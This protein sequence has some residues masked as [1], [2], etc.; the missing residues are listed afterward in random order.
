MTRTRRIEI[1]IWWCGSLTWW[2]GQ[3]P[4]RCTV[5]LALD[6]PSSDL[7]FVDLTRAKATS[8]SWRRNIFRDPEHTAVPRVRTEELKLLLI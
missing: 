4:A 8:K 7:I 2:W 3:A 1:R 5:K 6:G